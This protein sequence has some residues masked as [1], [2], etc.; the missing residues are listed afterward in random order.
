MRLIDADKIKW[1]PTVHTIGLFIPKGE[2]YFV[3]KADIDDMP[4]IKAEPI[5]HGH[6]IP[7]KIMFRTPFATN[8]DCSE[9]GKESF[10]TKYCPNC[11]AIMDEKENEE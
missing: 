10:Y 1:R 11:G 5:R 2:E 3:R 6:W 8:Y 7:H 4:T 9:C